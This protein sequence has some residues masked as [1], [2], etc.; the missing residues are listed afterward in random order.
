MPEFQGGAG[1]EDN[2]SCSMIHNNNG[3]VRQDIF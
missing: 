2:H 3:P 1:G